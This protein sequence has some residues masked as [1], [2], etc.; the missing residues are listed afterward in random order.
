M[1]TSHME[2]NIAKPKKPIQIFYMETLHFFSLL[3]MAVFN[4]KSRHTFCKL[5]ERHP[6]PVS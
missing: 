1:F 6:N 5:T 4:N 3:T 2:Q